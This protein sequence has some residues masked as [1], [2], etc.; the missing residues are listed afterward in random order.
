VRWAGTLSGTL[1]QNPKHDD[2]ANPIQVECANFVLTLTERAIK[3]I[4]ADTIIPT[5][6]TVSIL[7][8]GRRLMAS[9]I[10]P[11]RAPSLAKKLLEMFSKSMIMKIVEQ[12][13]SGEE[14]TRATRANEVVHTYCRLETALHPR[15]RERTQYV[16]MARWLREVEN[17]FVR[18]DA[19]LD[20]GMWLQ[21]SRYVFLHKP[22]SDR[23]H[24]DLRLKQSFINRAFNCIEL[25]PQAQATWLDEARRERKRLTRI[26]DDFLVQVTPPNE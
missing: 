7:R 15:S 17:L 19:P 12:H 23:L 6:I 3:E 8:A 4:N 2:A 10:L 18:Y 20:A 9:R 1:P 11:D 16:E 14:E 21:K 26:A 13:L 22:P 24:R 25:H 5:N